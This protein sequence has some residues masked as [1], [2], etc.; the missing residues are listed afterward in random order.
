MVASQP[1]P[2]IGGCCGMAM[3]V[4]GSRR[5]PALGMRAELPQEQWDATMVPGHARTPAAG[6]LLGAQRQVGCGV[7]RADVLAG[8]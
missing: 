1:L 8:G 5:S 3:G 7:G 2:F 4:E 6:A